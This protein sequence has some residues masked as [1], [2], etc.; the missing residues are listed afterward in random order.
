MKTEFTFEEVR[1]GLER[2]LDKQNPGGRPA[3]TERAQLLGV[4]IAYLSMVASGEM[5]IYDLQQ[6]LSE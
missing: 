1:R 3:G 6:R 4:A 2:Q 5:T